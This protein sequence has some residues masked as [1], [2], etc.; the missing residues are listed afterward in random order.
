M[1]QGIII[2]LFA[3]TAAQAWAAGAPVRIDEGD[4]MTPLAD[5]TVTTTATLIDTSNSSRATLNCT[6]NTEIRW[7]DSSVTSTK[8]N[9]VG[10]NIPFSIRNQGVVYFAA[11]ASTGTAS[12]TRESWSVAPGSSGVFSP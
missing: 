6:V 8:G 12:C 4:T 11:T 1:K 10:A 9:R 7:G 3:L 5:I 2:V